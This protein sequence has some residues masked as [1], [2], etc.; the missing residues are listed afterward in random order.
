MDGSP[1]EVMLCI[2]DESSESPG[3]IYV[4]VEEE[5]P[6]QKMLSFRSS[7][8]RPFVSMIDELPVIKLTC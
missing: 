2:P 5:P 6:L 4:D 8:P 1:N 3:R 7:G